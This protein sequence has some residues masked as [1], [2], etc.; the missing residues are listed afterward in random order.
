[1]HHIKQEGDIINFNRLEQTDEYQIV[2]WLRKMKWKI[3]NKNKDVELID[4]QMWYFDRI[5]SNNQ[6]KISKYKVALMHDKL[7]ERFFSLITPYSFSIIDH[8]RMRFYAHKY[9]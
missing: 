5:H 1:M 6:L 7:N 8:I 2:N 9:R 3:I 4:L